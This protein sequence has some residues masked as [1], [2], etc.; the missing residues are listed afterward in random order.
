M[1][2]KG[3]AGTICN[4][5]VKLEPVIQN[6]LMSKI[7]GKNKIFSE[8]FSF[9]EYRTSNYLR[10][11]SNNAG[12]SFKNIKVFNSSNHLRFFLIDLSH[13]PL[14]ECEYLEKLEKFLSFVSGENDHS[15]DGTS[16]VL[17]HY[18]DLRLILGFFKT[19][20]IYPAN[21]FNTK[22]LFN[23]MLWAAIYIEESELNFKRFS[24]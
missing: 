5:R 12:V 14:N 1:F 10:E 6:F 7:K 19:K 3:K 8:N 17:E 24:F 20:N 13:Q 9:Y 18:I 21:Y 22:S 16:C 2:F 15:L 11:I 23:N 4:K